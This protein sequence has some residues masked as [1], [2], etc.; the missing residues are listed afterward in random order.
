MIPYAFERLCLFETNKPL[1]KMTEDEM[2]HVYGAS[3]CN[4]VME[5][6][7]EAATSPKPLVAVGQGVKHAC[8]TCKVDLDVGCFMCESCLKSR[9]N[10]TNSVSLIRS[11]TYGMERLHLFE[12]GKP[13]GDMTESAMKRTYGERNAS[14]IRKKEAKSGGAEDNEPAAKRARQSNEE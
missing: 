2:K 10:W 5:E 14:L 7:I 9:D 4:V 1:G 11:V 12:T 3:R 8:L 6:E 13:L